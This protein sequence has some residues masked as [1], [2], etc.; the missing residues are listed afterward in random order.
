MIFKDDN[1]QNDGEQPWGD[2]DDKINAYPTRGNENIT[3]A[4]KLTSTAPTTVTQEI[5]IMVMTK[6]AAIT[7]T[8]EKE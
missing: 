7:K 2:N 5:M 1:K 4:L 8:V 6:T 3:M